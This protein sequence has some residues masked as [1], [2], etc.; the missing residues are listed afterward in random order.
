MRGWIGGHVLQGWEE[1]V[2]VLGVH[3]E[4]W[5]NLLHMLTHSDT[6]TYLLCLRVLIC[7]PLYI[8][9]HAW[10]HVWLCKLTYLGL[11]VCAHVFL[12]VGMCASQ[13]FLC[14]CRKHIIFI[15]PLGYRELVVFSSFCIASAAQCCHLALT[16][17][18]TDI[19]GELSQLVS[20]WF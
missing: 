19:L 6:F 13:C 8:F 11:F 9:M 18:T 14:K 12:Y 16:N 5:A 7:I 3:A 15:L 17:T 1:K 2:Q 4:R 20:V 10:M